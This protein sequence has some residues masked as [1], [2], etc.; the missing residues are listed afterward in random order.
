M[1]SKNSVKKYYY[2]HPI[3]PTVLSVTRCYLKNNFNSNFNDS[4]ILTF[5]KK[6]E[7]NNF[8]FAQCH[9]I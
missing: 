6:M 2:H 8:Q 4:T 9:T 5:N 3:K 1:S 7:N